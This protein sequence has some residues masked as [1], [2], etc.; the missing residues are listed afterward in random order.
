LYQSSAVLG[1]A[2]ALVELL[3]EL[4]L[5]VPPV[6]PAAKTAA[7]PTRQISIKR[8]LRIVSSLL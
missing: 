7:A 1:L 6:L 2:V 5:E 4:P 3:V 8:N